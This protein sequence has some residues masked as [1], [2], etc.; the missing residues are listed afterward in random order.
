M[1][2][3]SCASIL[4]KISY[5]KRARD[6]QHQYSYNKLSPVDSTKTSSHCKHLFSST[7][8]DARVSR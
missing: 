6:N 4:N 2:L 3:L 5:E 1:L 8:L 7:L